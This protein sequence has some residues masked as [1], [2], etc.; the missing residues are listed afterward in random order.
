MEDA[1]TLASSIATRVDRLVTN[2]LD[3]FTIKG[4]SRVDTRE[5]LSPGHPARQLFALVYDRNDGVSTVIAHPI[6]ALD[7]LRQGLWP[8]RKPSEISFPIR[9]GSHEFYTWESPGFG[10]GVGSAGRAPLRAHEAA[11]LITEKRPKPP[12]EAIPSVLRPTG[13]FPRGRSAARTYKVIVGPKYGKLMRGN[14]IAR[15]SYEVRVTSY[16]MRL[17]RNYCAFWVRTTAVCNALQS[18]SAATIPDW[19]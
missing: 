4:F 10:L 3:D 8:L 7:W 5:R 2:N 17:H 19:T 12:T 9:P 16:V 18:I 11:N 14:P 13:Q 15:Q 1:D 6:D